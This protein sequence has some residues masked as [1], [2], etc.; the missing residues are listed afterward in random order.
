MMLKYGQFLGPH[1]VAEVWSF[2]VFHVAEGHF[3]V[4][5]MLLKYGHF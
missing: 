4:S 3:L 5:M 1:D 2:L